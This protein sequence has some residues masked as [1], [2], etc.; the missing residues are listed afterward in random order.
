MRWMVISV[1]VLMLSP[2]PSSADSQTAMRGSSV[3]GILTDAETDVPI[4]AAEVRLRRGAVV[5]A[6]ATTDSEGSFRVAVPPGAY[7]IRF[8]QGKSILVRVFEV[9][10][11]KVAVVNGRMRQSEGEVIVVRERKRERKAKAVNY[12]PHKVPAYSDRAIAANRWAR[13]WLVLDVDTKGVVGPREVHAPTWV[14]TRRDRA[15]AGLRPQV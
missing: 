4:V 8:K 7:E 6:I 5:A 13:A 11:G 3:R 1:L 12:N 9:V 15:Q 10:P 2:S 14:W